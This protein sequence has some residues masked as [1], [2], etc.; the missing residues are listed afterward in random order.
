MARLALTVGYTSRTNA[1]SEQPVQLYLGSSFQ[2]AKEAA[3]NPP[4]GIDY[5][6]A[7]RLDSAATK[8]YHRPAA[9]PVAPAPAPVL[10]LLQDPPVEE[11]PAAEESAPAEEPAAEEDPGLDLGTSGRKPRGK[12]A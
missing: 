4:E 3:Q 2:A 5:A 9:A 12:Q 10:D 6:E 8:R 1:R 7:Y 11:A